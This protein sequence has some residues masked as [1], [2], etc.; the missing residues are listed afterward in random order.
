MNGGMRQHVG[1]CATASRPR[2][3]D[4]LSGVTTLGALVTALLL[5]A[6][7]VITSLIVVRGMERIRASQSALLAVTGS[8]DRVV[9]SDQ[10]KWSA[11]FSR[12]VDADDLAEG[13]A[14]MARDLGVVL[15]VLQEN[16]FEREDLTI[17]PVTLFSNY[18]DCFNAG[19]DCVREVT[20]HEL[21]QWF[22]LSSDRVDLVTR[23]AQD[24]SP[25]VAA[26]LNYQTTALEYYYSGLSD[27]RPELL[28]EAIADAQRRAEA[29]ASATGVGVGALRSADSGVFQVTQVNSTEVSGFGMYDTSTIEKRVTAVVHAS[30]SLE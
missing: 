9:T 11:A 21:Q 17:A 15:D 22:S 20:S 29:I 12:S 27:A 7:L 5:G 28:A 26:G 13:Y 24:A 3:T 6:A 25:F 10:V 19:P 23:L 18:R 14:A 2:P 30:F 4:R 16:G 1:P 8:A